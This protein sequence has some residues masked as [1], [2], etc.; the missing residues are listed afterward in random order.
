MSMPNRPHFRLHSRGVLLLTLTLLYYGA[1][2]TFVYGAPRSGGA[3][4]Q[5]PRP[6]PSP[7][8]AR[9]GSIQ[10]E[11][12]DSV[13][14]VAVARA[15]VGLTLTEIDADRPSSPFETTTDADGKFAFDQVPAG[16]YTWWV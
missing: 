13:T 7:A 4:S 9:T 3:L 8:A 1:A 10:G 2:P 11:V 5:P 6:S 14:G 16:D 15:R 12:V